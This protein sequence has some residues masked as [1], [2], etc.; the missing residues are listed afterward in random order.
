MLDCNR[1]YTFNFFLVVSLPNLM[2]FR[3]LEKM[4]LVAPRKK[5]FNEVRVPLSGQDPGV[6]S[7]NLDHRRRFPGAI[8]RF[9]FRPVK[10]HDQIKSAI[11]GW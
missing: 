9:L 8:Q 10:P 2:N 4:A 3:G 6:L 11:R 7:I 5:L 1:D